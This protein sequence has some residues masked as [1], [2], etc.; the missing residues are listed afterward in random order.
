MPRTRR[1]PPRPV[2][3]KGGEQVKWGGATYYLGPAGSEKAKQRYLQ[4]IAV[5]KSDP[6]A[7]PD[8]RDNYLVSEFARDYL[9]ASPMAAGERFKHKI[10]LKLLLE[11]H[12]ETPVEEFGPIALAAWQNWLAGREPK[13]TRTYISK[14]VGYVRAAWKWGVATERV[15][16]A[17]WQALGTVRGLR[18]G[19][20]KASRKPGKVTEEG[21]KRLL[22]ELRPAAAALLR[23]LRYTGARPSEL[24]GLRP[25][26]VNRSGD[27]WTF[28]PDRHKTAESGGSR[29]IHFGPKARAVLEQLDGR[30]DDRLYFP[31]RL[32]AAYN[33]NSL[34]YTVARACKR[35]GMP[36]VNLYDLRRAR[37]T[38]IWT[39]VGFE[40]SAAVGGHGVKVN[41]R[42]TRERTKLAERVAA[43]SG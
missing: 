40:A 42:Y 22:G 39:A 8:R 37:L 32:G 33:R 6:Y 27:V 16:M 14:L 26:D 30:A 9:K 31:N 35:L 20:A 41:E 4:L 1:F 11:L 38:E 19:Q 36:I 17:A 24:F 7:V 5:W 34:R 3:H 15:P 25:K 43:E 28:T 21:F 10:A 12:S 2:T 29:V 18:P 13:L 23:V